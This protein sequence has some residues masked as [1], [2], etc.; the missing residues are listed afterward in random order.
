MIRFTRSYCWE[1]ARRSFTPIF[2]RAPCR[3]NY[4]LDRKNDWHL[5]DVLYHHAKFGAD[6]TTRA[7][8]RCENVV[9]VGR[10][11]VAQGAH[12]LNKYCVTIYGRIFILFSPFSEGI[13]LSDRLESSHF[14]RRVAPQFSWNCG[15]KLRKLHKS[16]K[17]FV[18]TK[19]H[20]K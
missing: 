14:H 17:K 15:R 4:A 2:F 11:A 1:T 18:R 6:R 13:T 19:F 5:L 7:G 20:C 10:C 8:C 9:L 16:A 12:T 3:K